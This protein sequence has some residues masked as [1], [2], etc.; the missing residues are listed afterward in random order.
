[1]V[2][3]RPVAA[4]RSSLLLLVVVGYKAARTPLYL[5]IMHFCLLILMK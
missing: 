3:A 4:A 2:R 5:A 1:V